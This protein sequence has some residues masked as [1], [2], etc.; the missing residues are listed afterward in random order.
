[1]EKE[2]TRARGDE[3]RPCFIREIKSEYENMHSV[4]RPAGK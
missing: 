4:D 1:M 2:S 3:K